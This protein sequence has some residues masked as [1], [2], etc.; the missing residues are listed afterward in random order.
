MSNNRDEFAFFHLKIDIF[1]SNIWLPIL[2]LKN[3]TD[4]IDF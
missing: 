4:V 3:T 2:G 1:D